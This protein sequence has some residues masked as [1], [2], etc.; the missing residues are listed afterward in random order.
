MKLPLPIIACSIALLGACTSLATQAP[1]SGAADPVFTIAVIPDTQNYVDYN[2][3]TAEGFAFDASK[4]FLQ[5]MRYIADNL[6]SEGG[7]IAFVTSVGDV[8]Q[9]QTLEMDPE[10]A[11]LGFRRV[12]NPALDAYFAPTPKVLSVEIPAVREGFAMIAGKVPFAVAPGNHDHDAMW[13]DADHPPAEIIRSAA[14]VGMLHAGGLSTFKS[15]FSDQSD[16][17]RGQPWYVAAHDDG[18]SSAQ[19]FSGGRRDFLHISLVFAP[20]DDTL[21]W[22]EQVMASYPGLPTLITTHEYINNDGER[23]AN[24]VID[25][26]AV[27]PRHNTPEML[28]EKFIS[29]NDQIF[30]V[31]CGHHH[32]QA[33]RVDPNAFGNEVHQV[34]ADYQDRRQTAIDAGAKM[35]QGKGI[36]DGWMRMMEFDFSEET[37]RIRVRTYSTHYNIESSD[38]ETY[39]DWY[40]AAEK[41][42]LSNDAFLAED[43]FVIELTDFHARFSKDIPK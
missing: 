23:L 38:L 21:D 40:K 41:P 32:G 36:G 20:M 16:Y 30:L 24:P 1:V 26:H 14:D 6:E 33:Y 39:A 5:Q 22:A 42:D 28:W 9:H 34:L 43:E 12:A 19:I 18:A 29:K 4:L 8:W 3:Q 13:T 27:D 10:H 17:F 31:I 7:E 11:A 15:V 25:Q 37:P 35:L 2:H